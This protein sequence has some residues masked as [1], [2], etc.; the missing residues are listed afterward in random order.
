[1]KIVPICAESFG[2]N[3]Y[4]IVSGRSAFVVDPAVSVQAILS[5]AGREEALLEGILLT[6]GHFDHVL[7]LDTLRDAFP[8]PA[9]IHVEDRIL[10]TD[11]SK[12]A[13]STFFGRERVWRPAEQGLVG[14]QVIPLGDESITVLHTPGHTMGSVCYL[15]GDFLITGDT[16]FAEGYGR[17]DLWGGSLDLMRASLESLRNLP[18][19][20]TIYPGH[21]ASYRLS[22]ALDNVSYFL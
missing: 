3:T 1:M 13:F 2:A 11:G 18:K 5:A 8:I 20:L 4:L 15:C 22:H 6:H 19:D 16:L 7:S 9:Y 12:N 17:C 21:G 14:G 10:L